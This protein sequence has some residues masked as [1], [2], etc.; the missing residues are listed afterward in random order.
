MQNYALQMT[1]LEVIGK[2]RA[3]CSKRAADG[4]L[5]ISWD[6]G[7]LQSAPNLSGPWAAEPGASS[8]LT[9]SYDGTQKFYRLQVP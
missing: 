3:L 7:T 5:V 8:P 1:E 9:I 6:H 2:A 4:R